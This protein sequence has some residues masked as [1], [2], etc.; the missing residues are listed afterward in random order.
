VVLGFS[1]A[2]KDRI[3]MIDSSPTTYTER[4]MDRPFAEL[5]NEIINSATNCIDRGEDSESGKRGVCHLF[6]ESDVCM[7]G[8]VDLTKARLK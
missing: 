1:N 3:G 8:S 6:R 4:E 5:A 7:C 2:G